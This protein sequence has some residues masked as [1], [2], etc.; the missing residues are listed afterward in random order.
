MEIL[1][2]LR[3]RYTTKTYDSTFLLSDEQLEDIKEMLRLCPSSINSQPWAFELM[4]IMRQR[5]CLPS[6]RTP[7]K[8]ASSKP[9]TSSSSITIVT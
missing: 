6:T 2:I 5:A 7:T 3:S 1:D 8:T 9:V 4:A